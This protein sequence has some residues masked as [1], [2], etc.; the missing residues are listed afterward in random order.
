MLCKGRQGVQCT[1]VNPCCF[2]LACIKTFRHDWISLWLVIFIERLILFSFHS[3][4]FR[5]LF[6][7]M[8]LCICTLLPPNCCSICVQNV[9]RMN[10][11]HDKCVLFKVQYV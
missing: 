5:H 10:V 4:S 2:L 8:D 3:E 9:N 6:Y 1:L 11:T 7:V